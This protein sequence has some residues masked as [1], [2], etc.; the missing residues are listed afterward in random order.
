MSEI[1]LNY[2]NAIQKAKELEECANNCINEASE[3]EQ[4]AQRTQEAW[5]GPSGELMYEKIMEWAK[6]QKQYG[7]ELREIANRIRVI[8]NDIKERD[9]ELARL[10]SHGGPGGGYR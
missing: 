2:E 5:M 1:R 4:M 10:N 7:E 3:A 9:E 8:A 6:Q